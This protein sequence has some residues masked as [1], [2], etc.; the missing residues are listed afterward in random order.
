[1]STSFLLQSALPVIA[2]GDLKLGKVIGQG[3]YGTVYES[4][5]N[6]KQVAVK[7]LQLQKLDDDF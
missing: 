1:M 7:K 6:H 4:I 3:G 5:W 2:A